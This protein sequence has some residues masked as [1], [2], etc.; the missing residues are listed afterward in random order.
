M[1]NQEDYAHS[2]SSVKLFQRH[3]DFADPSPPAGRARKLLRNL[4][5]MPQVET[6]RRVIGPKSLDDILMSI[7]VEQDV[8]WALQ[9]L[10]KTVKEQ[11]A[12]S[13][14]MAQLKTKLLDICVYQRRGEDTHPKY[15]L[16][17]EYK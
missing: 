15:Y 1:H 7:L 16:K 2:L 12:V 14:N 13:V 5:E 4:D 10:A 8:G 11:G 6:L 17:A 9:Q 3:G